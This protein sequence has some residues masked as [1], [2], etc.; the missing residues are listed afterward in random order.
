MFTRHIFGYD[1]ACTTAYVH[2][3][4]LGEFS[5][6]DCSTTKRVPLP[7]PSDASSES[8]RRDVS[9]AHLFFGIGNGT[10]LVVEQSSLEDT[11]AV[12]TAEISTMEN[13]P[14]GV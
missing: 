12:P 13:R 1:Y 11:D 7:I 4:P 8:S 9:D 6:L 5:K 3:T 2:H 14:R 10:L